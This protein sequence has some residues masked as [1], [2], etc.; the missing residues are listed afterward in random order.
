MHLCNVTGLFVL[1]SY[2]MKW[3]QFHKIINILP[4]SNFLYV[5]KET[6]SSPFVRV[7]IDLILQLKPI[8]IRERDIFHFKS[9][10][11]IYEQIVKGLKSRRCCSDKSHSEW[12]HYV[13]MSRWIYL[14]YRMVVIGICNYILN[15]FVDVLFEIL[16]YY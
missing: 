6:F 1:Y 8:P 5:Y 3:N 10:K 16:D 7:L 14:N 15:R 4:F 11:N 9:L 13:Q 12:S 2:Q